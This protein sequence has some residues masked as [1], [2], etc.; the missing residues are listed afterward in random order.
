MVSRRAATAALLLTTGCAAYGW[1][2]RA[3]LSSDDQRRASVAVTTIGAPADHLLDLGAAT[4]HLISKLAQRGVSSPIWTRSDDEVGAVVRCHVERLHTH[5]ILDSLSC[6]LT[7]ACSLTLPA[8]QR[9][10]V[11]SPAQAQLSFSRASNPDMLATQRLVEMNAL[12]RAID[13]AAPQLAQ[14]I[15]TH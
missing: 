1:T 11:R 10:E 12:L 3:D 4:S 15:P 2:D 5:A 6:D 8:G 13:D 9:H 14:H 7:L